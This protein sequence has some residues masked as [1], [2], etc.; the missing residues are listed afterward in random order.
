MGKE[1]ELGMKQG[2][3]SN[4][5]HPLAQWERKW[6]KSLVEVLC[7]RNNKTHLRLAPLEQRL[8]FYFDGL[9]QKKGI[10]KGIQWVG[11]NAD[12]E[13]APRLAPPPPLH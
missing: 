9:E 12:D 11:S 4:K 10:G 1:R 8:G 2:G 7:R 6:D 5:Y 13:L 3:C